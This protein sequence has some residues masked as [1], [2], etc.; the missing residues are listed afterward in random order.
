MALLTTFLGVPTNDS[1]CRFMHDDDSATG[2]LVSNAEGKEWI[3]YGD[4]QFFS[5]QNSL[6]RLYRY[7]S[8]PIDTM[9]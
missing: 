7:G 2:L 1:Q 3:A 9:C 6:N 8:F 5:P 4:K